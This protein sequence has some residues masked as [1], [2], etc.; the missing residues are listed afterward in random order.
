MTLEELF[1]VIKG[2]LVTAGFRNFYEQLPNRVLSE[3]L[4]ATWVCSDELIKT[5]APAPCNYDLLS[6]YSLN[7]DTVTCFDPAKT[8]ISY[9]LRIMV[10]Q[11]VSGSSVSIL[12]ISSTQTEKTIRRKLVD[13][14]TKYKELI[15]INCSK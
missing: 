1:T 6:G 5:P 12:K 2:E 9:Y 3:S 8:A 15:R 14:I 10:W 13:F 4:H 11:G 7:T